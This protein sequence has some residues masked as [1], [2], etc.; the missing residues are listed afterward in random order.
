MTEEG[1]KEE[2][3]RRRSRATTKPNEVLTSDDLRISEEELAR[4]LWREEGRLLARHKPTT[5]EDRDK[6]TPGEHDRF[7][8]GPW[9][10]LRDWLNARMAERDWRPA[11]LERAYK[12]ATGD[13]DRSVYGMIHAWTRSTGRN[14]RRPSPANLHH[15]AD[16]FGVDVDFL[17]GLA[18]YRVR[19]EPEE[20]PELADL[21]SRFRSIPAT[22][23]NV[24]I[25]RAVVDQMFR[26]G[27]VEARTRGRGTGA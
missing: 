15:L 26:I 16:V 22:P 5:E 11:D 12:A 19:D 1:P 23:E 17:M 13:E 21:W 8:V 27:R 25:L 9:Q 6:T 3:R 20:D 2:K 18:G 7:T 24:A 4:R 14:A 10:P